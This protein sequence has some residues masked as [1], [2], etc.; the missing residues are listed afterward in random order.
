MMLVPPSLA[1]AEKETVACAL[2]ATALTLCGA[3]GTENCGVTAPL[4]LEAVPAPTAF[5]ARTVNV[6][7]IPLVSP[8]T[9]SG[10][11]VP[12]AVK[13]PGLEVAV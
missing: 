3:P 7:E 6:Y 1:G 13:P 11:D 2:P 12:D 8:V 4:A 5:V 10:L 9:M